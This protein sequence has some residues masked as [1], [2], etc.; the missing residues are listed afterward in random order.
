ML[1]QL[2]GDRE[3]ML[4]RDLLKSY[5]Y[6]MNSENSAIEE[7]DLIL[8]A[9]ISLDIDLSLLPKTHKSSPV[10]TDLKSIEANKRLSQGV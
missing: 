5:F 2:Y 9:M 1:L 10:K 4:R 7:E 8:E 6:H 3:W